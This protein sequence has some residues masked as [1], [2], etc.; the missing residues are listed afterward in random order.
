MKS[1]KD[2]NKER[3]L[4]LKALSLITQLG[5]IMACCIVIGLF[6]GKFLDGL[7]GTSPLFMIIFIFIGSGSAIKV[8]YDIVK[9]WK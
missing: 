2:K 1:D 7:L 9:D 4:I 3:R 6:A 8:M 5:L